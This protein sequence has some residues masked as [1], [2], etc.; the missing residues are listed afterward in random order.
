[1]TRRGLLLTL[2]A[3]VLAM[4]VLLLGTL[5]DPPPPVSRPEATPVVLPPTDEETTTTATMTTVSSGSDSEGV[6]DDGLSRLLGH[7]LQALVAVGALALL[8]ALV[9]GGR[10]VVRRRPRILRAVE[11]FDVPAVPDR[12]LRSAAEREAVLEAGEPRNA[13]VAAWLSLEEAIAES[14]LPREPAETST[15]YTARVLRTWDVDRGRI[16]ELAALYREARFSRHALTET[17]RRH[18][19]A[20]LAV[21]HED[22]LRVARTRTAAPERDR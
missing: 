8:A 15:E 10:A 13:I 3:A 21:L 1:M 18:A 5:A 11:S 2:G 19:V 9:A 16:A 20:A 7:L 6:P 17:H 4:A 12:V 14:G 22:L